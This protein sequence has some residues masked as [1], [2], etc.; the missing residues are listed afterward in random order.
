MALTE[1]KRKEDPSRLEILYSRLLSLCLDLLC[2]LSL[3][4]RLLLLL[5][6]LLLLRC[7]VSAVRELALCLGRRGFT[8]TVLVEVSI[9]FTGAEH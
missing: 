8:P 9:H 2:V 6:L 4:L 3:L 7:K 5:L 1:S